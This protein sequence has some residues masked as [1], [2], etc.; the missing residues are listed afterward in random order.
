MMPGPSVV[1]RQVLDSE[2]KDYY[3]ANSTFEKS[4]FFWRPSLSRASAPVPHLAG[5]RTVHLKPGLNEQALQ[6]VE[7]QVNFAV[8]VDPKSA[9]FEAKDAGKPVSL[10]AASVSLV[11]LT[12]NSAKLHYRGA[13]E[14]LLLV[15]GYGADGKALAV[16]SRQILPR[17]Q[18]VDQDFTITFKGPVAKVEFE[19]AARIIERVFAFSLARGA[20]AGPAPAASSGI[21]LPARAT[22][23][24][25][26]TPAA[27]QPAAPAPAPAPAP[28]AAPAPV[29]APAPAPAPVPTAAP[30]A[31]PTTAAA[32]PA[33]KP[34]TEPR[35]PSTPP[36]T[37]RTLGP[38]P[39]ACVYKP[40]MT[41]EDLARC[42]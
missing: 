41:D 32:R 10:H 33:P 5:T 18:D 35:A 15:R 6:K 7:G 19:V 25:A 27:A 11:S 31:K 30:A 14:H 13:S 22:Q 12:G 42:R 17:N 4:D 21:T 16:E 1:V 2:G 20:A 9:A 28:A 37:A 29:A 3:D 34:R 23:A 40:V 8:P 38:A 24:A 36:A 39:S 26:A